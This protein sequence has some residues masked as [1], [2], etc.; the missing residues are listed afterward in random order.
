MSHLMLF[1][2]QTT[3]CDP[4]FGRYTRLLF[5]LVNDVAW[6]CCVSFSTQLFNQNSDDKWTYIIKEVCSVIL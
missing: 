6:H 5:H 4:V 1:T 3:F 2:R